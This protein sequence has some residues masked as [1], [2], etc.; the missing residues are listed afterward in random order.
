M[1]ENSGKSSVSRSSTKSDS[2]SRPSRGKR[3][4]DDNRRVSALLVQANDIVLNFRARELAPAGIS[5]LEAEVLFALV[6]AKAPTT[7]AEISRLILRR[8]EGTSRVIQRMEAKGLV[9]KSKHP[10]RSNLVMVSM[11]DEGRKAHEKSLNKW[12]MEHPISCLSERQCKQLEAVLR[13]ILQIS[14]SQ[15]GIRGEVP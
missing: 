12:S 10:R 13:K 2:R 4:S 7:P 5:T 15:P 3:T 9:T 14:L 8:P 11:T 1:A 6:K